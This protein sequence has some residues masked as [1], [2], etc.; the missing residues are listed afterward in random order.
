MK[1]R[2]I[3][4]P[5]AGILID[6]SNLL[7]HVSQNLIVP[8]LL[9][10][11]INFESGEM[12]SDV[13]SYEWALKVLIHDLARRSHI[14]TLVSTAPDTTIFIFGDFSS[15]KADALVKCPVSFPAALF[16]LRSQLTMVPP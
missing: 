14:L 8:S 7:A 16:S 12:S 10:D 11:T 13:T 4:C 6:L 1:A 5:A 2:Q 9:P 3:G 15:I